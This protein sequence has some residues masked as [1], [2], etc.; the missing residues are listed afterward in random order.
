MSQTLKPIAETNN[1]IVL[2]S[3]ERY[4]EKNTGHQSEDALEREFVQ[5][6]VNQG[7]EF[8]KHITT[9]EAML[10]NVRVQ[11]EDLNKVKFSSE[12]WSRFVSQYLDPPSENSTDKARKIHD[13]YIKDFVFDDGH[14]E[15]IKLIDKKH[16]IN[17]KLQVIKQFEQT[18]TIKTL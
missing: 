2:D 15:N 1:F 14:I 3:Y 8:A 6:L 18:G 17:N 12:E 5:D 13:D 16:V 7:Y 4:V 11:L 9:P 10:A